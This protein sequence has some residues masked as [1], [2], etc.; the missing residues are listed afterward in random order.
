MLLSKNVRSRVR[1]QP[2]AGGGDK[3]QSSPPT[4]L[5]GDAA[6]QNLALVVKD[7]N[8]TIWPDAPDG[9]RRAAL[10]PRKSKAPPV[11]AAGLLS[12]ITPEL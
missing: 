3:R 4:G 2:I 12:G 11:S 10:W 9:R 1:N 6:P 8:L 5:V 7:E